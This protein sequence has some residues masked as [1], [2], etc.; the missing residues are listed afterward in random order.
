MSVP[1]KKYAAIMMHVIIDSAKKKSNSLYIIRRQTREG[2]GRGGRTKRRSGSY[3][4]DRFFS[5]EK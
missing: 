5:I 2:E 1:T 3:E 4:T